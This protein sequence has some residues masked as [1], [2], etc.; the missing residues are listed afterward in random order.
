MLP[1]VYRWAYKGL[2]P[3]NG[4]L[5]SLACHLSL[6]YQKPSPDEK[7]SRPKSYL[8]YTELHKS[9]ERTPANRQEDIEGERTQKN[10]NQ[11][12]AVHKES[13]LLCW[14]PE[15]I[16]AGECI[17]CASAD[18]DDDD[19][20][21]AQRV[22]PNRIPQFFFIFLFFPL[23]LSSFQCPVINDFKFVIFCFFSRGRQRA[24]LFSS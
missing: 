9:R 5:L 20:R 22:G 12:G 11:R 1:S 21:A 6:D 18:D 3:P 17:I 13:L 2:S 23:L 19:G 14:K 10:E 4:K 7:N 15:V 24:K 8:C 16:F